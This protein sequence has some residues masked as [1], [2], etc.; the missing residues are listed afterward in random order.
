MMDGWM[1]DG[2]M[3]DGWMGETQQN[4]STLP[5]PE[6]RSTQHCT[7]RQRVESSYGHVLF[8]PQRDVISTEDRPSCVLCSSNFS[9]LAVDARNVSL[10]NA[11]RRTE[12]LLR[13]GADGGGWRG[14]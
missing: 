14:S 13:A 2:W 12:P 7:Q 11:A 9:P 4:L 3:N 6:L 5:S 8:I 10:R 1:N